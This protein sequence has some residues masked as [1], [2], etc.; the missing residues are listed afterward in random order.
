MAASEGAYRVTVYYD[1]SKCSLSWNVPYS[2]SAGNPYFDATSYP[3]AILTVTPA[4]GY[5]ISGFSFDDSM[6]YNM[7]HVILG[8][9]SVKFTFTG[10][11]LDDGN[12]SVTV[13][14]QA[15]VPEVYETLSDLFTGI[16]N[17]IRTKDGS[18]GT[19]PATDFPKRIRALG[20]SSGGAVSPP[21]ASRDDPEI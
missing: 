1:S 7:S 14:T 20:A 10:T 15:V 6:T 18:T 5:Q 9:N 11:M 4:S 2:N 16:A 19:I 21:E 13:T 8:S 12:A 17:A 3:S